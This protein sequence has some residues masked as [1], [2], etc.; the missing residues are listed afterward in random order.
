[1]LETKPIFRQPIPSLAQWLGDGTRAEGFEE[2]LRETLALES[3]ALSPDEAAVVRMIQTL[4]VAFMEVAKNESERHGRPI[5][6]TMHH[7]ARAAGVAVMSPILSLC[8][9]D[10]SHLHDLVRVL[11]KDFKIGAKMMADSAMRG[12][13]VKS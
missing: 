7:L 5:A 9:D 6:S 2:W 13:H 10:A 8:R 4:A 11:A 1:M 3:E 12:G